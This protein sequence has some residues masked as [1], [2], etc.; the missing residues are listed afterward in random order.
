[1]ADLVGSEAD[2]SLLRQKHPNLLRILHELAPSSP[3]LRV[4][5]PEQPAQGYLRPRCSDPFPRSSDQ[6]NVILQ[7]KALQNERLAPSLRQE[8]ALNIGQSLLLRKRGHK[9]C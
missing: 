7:C 5:D 4:K 1:M 9:T 8:V 6:A 2:L 3:V